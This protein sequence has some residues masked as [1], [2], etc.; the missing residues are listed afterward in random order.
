V[1]AV[2]AALVYDAIAKPGR[3]PE[4]VRDA[5]G[6]EGSI[7]GRRVLPNQPSTTTGDTHGR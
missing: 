5:Q 3:S 7:E 1:G 6:T 2:I 4:T